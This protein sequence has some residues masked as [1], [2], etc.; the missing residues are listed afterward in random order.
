[1]EREDKSGLIL[2]NV[3]CAS[4]CVCLCV[5]VCMCVC[6]NERGGK[7]IKCGSCNHLK[8]TWDVPTKIQQRSYIIVFTSQ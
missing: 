4:V 6:V 2:V 8:L 1:M 7:A 3:F 5:C